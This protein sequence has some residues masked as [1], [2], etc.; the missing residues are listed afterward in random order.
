M[1][2][3]SRPKGSAHTPLGPTYHTIIKRNW[4]GVERI[5]NTNKKLNIDEGYKCR[6][7]TMLSLLA[8]CT[9]AFKHRCRCVVSIFYSKI[10]H[11]A[12]LTRT[13]QF[14][15]FCKS[16]ILAAIKKCFF[17]CYFRLCFKAL[18]I[19][20]HTYCLENPNSLLAM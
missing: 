3:L 18:T 2:C 8:L 20:C 7:S 10:K 1:F 14:L 13:V 4:T 5:N 19:I 6:L 12:R 11:K 15:M 9:S 17:L 16:W